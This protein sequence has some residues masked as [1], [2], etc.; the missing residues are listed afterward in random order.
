MPELWID[1]VVNGWYLR[2]V[3][4]AMFRNHLNS[5]TTSHFMANST[6]I[7]KNRPS[8]TELHVMSIDK[9]CFSQGNWVRIP[10]G[11]LVLL[12]LNTH[13]IS[14]G[15][16]EKIILWQNGCECSDFVTS[17]FQVWDPFNMIWDPLFQTTWGLRTDFFFSFSLQN[18][19]LWTHWLYLDSFHFVSVPFSPMDL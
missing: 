9:T 3:W 16:R 7:N 8:L 2:Q 15:C 19:C 12:W 4:L 13:K 1:E 5:C 18:T 10:T 14:A 11:Y 6:R 17:A